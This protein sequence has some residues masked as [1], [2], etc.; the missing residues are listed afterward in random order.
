[1]GGSHQISGHVIP[2]ECPRWC[3]D[4][5]FLLEEIPTTSSPIA[6]TPGPSG[7]APPLDVAH[8]QEEATKALGDLLVTKSS[9]DTCQQ[10]LV[11]DFSMTPWQNESKTLQSIKEARAQCDHSIKEVDACWSL[12]IWEV[13]SQ[14]ATQ[15]C[16][17]Q[18]S[19]AK[20]VQ[21]LEEESLEKERRD[22]LNF[23][24]VCQA[25]LDASPPE[26]HGM[27]IAPYHLL[28]G[29][30]PISNHFTILPGA[31][32][33]Q[34]GSI[35]GVPSPLAP[36]APGPLPRPMQQHHLPDPAGLLPPTRPCPRQLPRGPLVQSGRR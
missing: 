20:D 15:S 26:S 34:Q 28:L 3:K 2:S 35:P 11:S 30:A 24:S 9:I 31:S 1:M 5:G 13:E 29:H 16:S 19:H 25:A 4:G 22:Q 14:G 21:H 23:L 12:A 17:F 7:D 27:L 32:P 6:R 33:P 18:Q 8:L 36:T 10:K